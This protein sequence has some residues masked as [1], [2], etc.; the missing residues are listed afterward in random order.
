MKTETKQLKIEVS[1]RNVVVIGDSLSLLDIVEI[2]L[3]KK[4][5]VIATIDEFDGMRKI[6]KFNPICVFIKI[7]ADNTDVISA[8][9]AKLSRKGEDIK[10]TPVIA[11]TKD[12]ISTI[13]E[14]KLKSSG[15]REIIKFPITWG[16]F[17]EVIK[18]IIQ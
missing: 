16:D 12:E 6:E 3:Y 10:D 18:P 15:I 4:Y 13:N 8:F 17:T 1:K 11:F 14:F 5:N 7:N 2:Y 9:T